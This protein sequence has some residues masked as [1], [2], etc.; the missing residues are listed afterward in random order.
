MVVVA[1]CMHVGWEAAQLGVLFP[2]HAGCGLIKRY[3]FSSC[4]MLV[5]GGRVL[6]LLVL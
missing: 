4:S 1:S 5:V 2:I 3:G 6:E